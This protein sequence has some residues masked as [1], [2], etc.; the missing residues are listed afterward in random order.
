MIGSAL[1][2]FSP[3]SS[4]TSQSPFGL[5]PY[6]G[7]SPYAGLSPYGTQGAYVSP[8]GGPAPQVLQFLQ[9]VPQQLHQLQQLEY[10]QQQ[11]LQQ[12]LQ[13][14]PAQLAQLQQLIQFVIHSVQQPNQMQ[15]P[16]GQV[17]GAG[18]FGAAPPWGITPQIFGAQPGLVM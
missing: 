13:V 10:I 7:L 3:L 11:Q 8:F 18:I 16:F 14:V 12:I 15:Q 4:G 6:G 1:G 2:S 5:S 9:Y 17:Q